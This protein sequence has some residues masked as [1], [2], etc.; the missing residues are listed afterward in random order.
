MTQHTIIVGNNCD[1]QHLLTK[2]VTKDNGAV[3]YNALKRKT[4]KLSLLYTVIQRRVELSMARFI[5]D[6]LWSSFFKCQC[7]TRP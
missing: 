5:D 6:C 4:M 2:N 1:N 3:L 7:K